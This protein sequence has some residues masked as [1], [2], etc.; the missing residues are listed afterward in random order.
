M[1]ESIEAPTPEPPPVALGPEAPESPAPQE[2]AEAAPQTY[3]PAADA[4]DETWRRFHRAL[5]QPEEAS[6]Y[7][8][9]G[10]PFDPAAA[11]DAEEL[12]G[13]VKLSAHAAGISQRQFS[14]LVREV[15]QH[16]TEIA[17]QRAE[18]T[19]VERAAL[20]SEIGAPAVKAA[21]RNLREVLGGLA[22]AVLQSG[23]RLGDDARFLRAFSGKA[24]PAAA[25]T[26]P[27]SPGDAQAEL[28]KLEAD[29]AFRRDLYDPDPFSP[30]R[31]AAE[32]RW[33]VLH[34][35]LGGQK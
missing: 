24:T 33:N 3:I 35:Q 10:L 12:I 17:Q 6:D 5:G 16:T 4:D 11:P 19:A 7:D 21:E 25:P 9:S 22:D 13:A 20:T 14:S 1:S 31:Q 18:Q 29:P 15:S 32:Q 30:K 23:V 8:T 26:E 34:R 2:A 28:E 27:E